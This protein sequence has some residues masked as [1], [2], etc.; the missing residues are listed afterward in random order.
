M[1][2][3][4]IKE[5]KN[6]V[7]R[8]SGDSGDGMQLVGSI[9]SNLSAYLGNEITTLPDFPTEIR[10]PRG[11]LSGV[12][13]YQVQIGSNV[14]TPGNKANILIAMNP[15]ALKVNAKF[16][17]SDSVIIIDKD[18]F[19]LSDLQKASFS[20]DDPF[21][22][23]ELN[24]VQIIAAPILQM[25]RSCLKRD[26]KQ[27][28]KNRNIFALG[29]VCWLLN[30]PIEIAEKFLYKKLKKNSDVLYDIKN[31][32][33]AGYNYGH[34]T[35]NSIA[36]YR[37]EATSHKNGYYTN[38]DGNKATAYG[39]IAASEKSSLPLFLAS[40]PITPATDIM[41]ELAARKELNIKTM[42]AEDEIASACIAIGASF[43]GNL[44][45]TTTSGPG[46]ALKGEAIGLA[47]M[48]EIPLVIIDVQR[49]G[50]STGLPTKSEQSDL[51]Q[52]LYGRNGESPVVVISAVSPTNCFNMAFWACKLAIEHLTP[53]ILLTDGYIANGSSAWRIPNIDE[54]P[55]IK[56]PY[57]TEN[58]KKNWHPYYR[59]PVNDV[60]YWALPG[61]EGFSHRIGGLE[62]N[63]NTSAIS[64]DAL[65]H[66]K[67]VKIRQSKIDK[68]AKYIPLQKI[69][70][71]INANLLIIGW[72]GT[73]GH[74]L[75]A[76]TQIH[77]SNL[78]VALIHLNF[79]CPLPLNVEKI[80]NKYKKIL[81]V[82]Q[83]LGQLANYLRSKINGF[84]TYQYNQIDGQPINVTHLVEK[85]KQLL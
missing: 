57:V 68:I 12:S 72:G 46:L 66:Q 22:E 4:K 6:V 62:K 55:N 54:Y 64:I 84:Q 59:N 1:N 73:Y 41:Q 16:L 51:M 67:M 11:S 15:A 65:N 24:S 75:E 8:F 52:A 21:K 10:S 40:Y 29:L 82:E 25:C 38:I 36:T 31:T 60:R 43:A 26:N 77:K 85:I 50:P 39:L 2:E 5:L 23:L 48:A 61:K 78:E 33:L 49:C 35:H 9:F 83:N 44:S 69:I 56:P 13:G 20:T 47:V 74:L 27:A 19:G 3:I 58:I 37:I 17:Y 18:S 63:C 81:V 30:H 7:I 42:Q 45:V 32:L 14:Y 28:T 71:D 34:N 70:G 53:V 80:I 76:I 79:I